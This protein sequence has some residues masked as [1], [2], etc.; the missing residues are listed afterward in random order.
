VA[1]YYVLLILAFA[2]VLVYVFQSDPCMG[3][4]RAD[5]ATKHPSYE[6]LDSGAGTASTDSVECHVR[7]HKPESDRVYEDVW[8][9]QNSADGWHFSR[10]VETSKQNAT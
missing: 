10:I 8:V 5:F 9:Y 3:Q 4:L 1:K 7:Y 2:G 6:I